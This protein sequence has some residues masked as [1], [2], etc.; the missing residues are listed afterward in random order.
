[1]PLESRVDRSRRQR[2][3][4]LAALSCLMD[5]ARIHDAEASASSPAR[6]LP[7][8]CVRRLPAARRR[9]SQRTMPRPARQRGRA[10]PGKPNSTGKDSNAAACARRSRRLSRCGGTADRRPTPRSSVSSTRP[11]ALADFMETCSATCSAT[12]RTTTRPNA[13]RATAIA[14]N[15]VGEVGQ[16]GADLERARSTLDRR[17]HRRSQRHA[18]GTRLE[19]IEAVPDVPWRGRADPAQPGGA[20]HCIRNACRQPGER[21]RDTNRTCRRKSNRQHDDCT[22]SRC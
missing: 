15:G 21:A 22:T 2:T 4:L 20:R 9:A 14:R 18:L 6:R 8:V 5:D 13:T 11:A 1:M 19:L 17:S 12:C 16:S 7:A 10:N 3:P